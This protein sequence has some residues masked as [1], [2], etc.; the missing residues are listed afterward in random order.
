MGNLSNRATGVKNFAQEQQTRRAGMVNRAVGI[1][2]PNF[3]AEAAATQVFRIKLTNSGA[4]EKRIVL[5]PG[6]LATHGEINA[7][8]GISADAIA[9]NGETIPSAVTCSTKGNTSVEFLQKFVNSNPTRIIRIQV[10]ASTETQLSEDLIFAKINPF[11]KAGEI[12]LNPAATKKETNNQSKLVTLNPS[13]IQLDDQTVW[14]VNILAGATL[15]LNLTMG[16]SSNRAAV[17]SEQ[18]ELAYGKSI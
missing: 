2:I 4:T 11:A 17:L 15:T 7:I 13:N 14:F 5:H 10:E 18:A 6:M 8:L 12:T 3:D 16:V 9:K 1:A